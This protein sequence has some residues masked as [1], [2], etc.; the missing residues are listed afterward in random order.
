MVRDHLALVAY[1]RERMRTGF[2][3]GGQDCVTFAAGAVE[4]QTG[5]DPL[6]E[7]SSRWSTERGAARVLKTFGGM[8]AAVSSVLRP[9][10]P[11]MAARGDVA[12]WLDGK[13]R[14]QLAIVEGETLIGPG[15]A[16]L[17]RLP[18]K[19]MVKAWSAER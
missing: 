1:M 17:T 8:E 9:I 16:G 4:A 13:G 14:L 12:G 10:A 3:W 7:I 11:A 6:R 5:A 15:Q 2:A 18:R 19:A